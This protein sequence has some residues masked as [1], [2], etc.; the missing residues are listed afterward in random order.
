MEWR[1]LHWVVLRG[2]Q[3]EQGGTEGVLNLSG[4]VLQ[5]AKFR[6]QMCERSYE[7]SDFFSRSAFRVGPHP[8]GRASIGAPSDPVP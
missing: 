8:G 6:E 1:R 5:R 4:M 2:H 3:T 7:A